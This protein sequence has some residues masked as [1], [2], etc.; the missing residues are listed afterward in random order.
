[1]RVYV[2]KF[3]GSFQILAVGGFFK[4]NYW[5]AI[6][7]WSNWGISLQV[8]LSMDPAWPWPKKPGPGLYVWTLENSIRA[9]L[10]GLSWAGSGLRKESISGIRPDLVLRKEGRAFTRLHRFTC[11]YFVQ[12]V[13]NSIFLVF[14]LGHINVISPKGYTFFLRENFQ[15]IH[16]QKDI[17]PSQT[18]LL[19]ES[20]L[21]IA[22]GPG[23]WV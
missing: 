12:I 17:Q 15:S 21:Q 4:D 14:T 1:M 19:S 13:S 5:L 10:L 11:M 20:S 3:I 7:D 2:P 22:L 9:R 23:G 16:L 18:N 8:D 6:N